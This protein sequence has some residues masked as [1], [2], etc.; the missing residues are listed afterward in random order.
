M[1]TWRGRSAFG[2][3]SLGVLWTAALIPGAFVFPAYGGNATSSSGSTVH[4]TD[5]LVGVNG[6]WVVA[7][8]VLLLL[9]SL[10]AWLG[11]HASCATGSRRGRRVG[12]ISAGLL[13]VAAVLTFSLGFLALPAALL[14][15]VAARLTPARQAREM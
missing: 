3:A 11:L 14:L 10:A 9:L 13:V 15:V 2:L 6:S 5:T 1:D 12:E 8:L 7:P 4:T